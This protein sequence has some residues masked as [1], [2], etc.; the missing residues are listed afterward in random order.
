MGVQLVKH[1]GVFPYAAPMRKL[2]V[3]MTLMVVGVVV[4]GCGGDD[5]PASPV[6]ASDGERIGQ[7]LSS[8]DVTS[9]RCMGSDDYGPGQGMKGDVPE[10]HA[11]TERLVVE[12]S[13]SRKSRSSGYWMAKAPLFL[14]IGS[15]P[16]EIAVMSYEGEPRSRLQYSQ[17]GEP[18]EENTSTR[19]R[20]L[21]CG[22][23]KPTWRGYAGAIASDGDPKCVTV[24]MKTADDYPSVIGIPV[25]GKCEG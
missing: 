2:G 23:E 7:A 25:N 8:T 1:S 15:E 6:A 11:K 12:A 21:P 19:V 10:S 9:V 5:A 20:F 22:D 3:W 17:R 14:K 16:I 24:V 4:S 13:D 18:N